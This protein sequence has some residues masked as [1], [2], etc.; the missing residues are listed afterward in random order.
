[1]D[2]ARVVIVGGGFAGLAAAEMLQRGGHRVDVTLVDRKPTSDFLP[3]LPDVIGERVDPDH[4]LYDFA[5]LGRELGFQF[6]Q[7]EVTA[8]DA[9][10]RVV[11]V[12]DRSLPFD[13]AIVATGTQ[14]AFH[15]N[16][17][18][19]TN[20]L[21]LDTV[22]DARGILAALGEASRETFVVVG[23]G[24]T[25]IEV[26]TNIAAYFR[27]RKQDRRVLV[28]ELMPQILA[29][30]R[31]EFRTYTLGNLD[32]M[33]IEVRTEETVDEIEPDRCRLRSGERIDHAL[34]IWNAGTRAGGFLAG[35]PAETGRGGRIAVDD[36]L[37]V[38]DRVSVIGDAAQFVCRGAPLRMAVQF[39]LTQGWRAGLNV[40]RSL[41]GRGPVVYRPHDLGIVVP[42]ANNRSC[43][44]AV[45]MPVY[46]RLATAL[47]YT[48]CIWRS[49]GIGRRLRMIAGLRRLFA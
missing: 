18:A 7:A 28:C 12:P 37:R 43:G 5:A 22:A 1:M 41:G 21:H 11:R 42:M 32:R 2:A 26:A 10:E 31:P 47:H 39:S 46:G 48:M 20:A 8:V 29:G 6:V 34:V 40:L 17:G 38:D 25:G 44:R 23:G 13:H 45:Q 3:M 9:A 36:F 16:E 24:Y 27:R 19:K 14:T 15:G 49:R 33:N 4:L 30:L 35:L